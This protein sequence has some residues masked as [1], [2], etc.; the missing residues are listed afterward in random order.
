MKKILFAASAAL[1]CFLVSCSSKDAGGKLSDKAQK[2]LDATHAINKCFETT[3][4][5]KL[6]DYIVTDAVDH[7]GEH[8]DVVGLDSIKAELVEMCKKM[9]DMKSEVVK[10]FADD[11]WVFSWQ[12]NSGT[13]KVAEMGMQPGSKY[14]FAAIEVSKFKDGKAT[15]HWTFMSA[16]DMMKM[17]QPMMDNKMMDNKMD[18]TKKM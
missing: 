6:G 5:S 3:D 12:K 10:E 13:M 2:N 14:S 8:G 1:V 18:T 4:F 9:G 15:E 16:A 7:A 11:D 17:M